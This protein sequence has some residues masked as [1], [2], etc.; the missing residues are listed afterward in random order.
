MIFELADYFLCVVNDFT[1]LDQRYLDRLTRSLQNSKKVFQE[2]IVVHNCKTVMEAEVM[3]HIFE[4]QIMHV[5]GKGK[6]QTTRIAAVNRLTNELEEHDVQWFKTDFSRHVLLANEDCELGDRT[7]PWAFALLKNWLRSAFVPVNRRFSVLQSVLQ[8]CNARL[9]SYF[10]VHPEL[11]VDTTDDRRV[12]LIRARA[13]Q[14]QMR[15][16]QTSIDASGLLLMRPNHFLPHVDIVKDKDYTIFLDVPGMTKE[17]IRLSRQNVTTIVKGMRVQPYPELQV[18][19]IERSERTYGDFTLTFAI[20]Q[21]YER[22]WTSM[23]LEKG[24]LRIVFKPDADEE[25]LVLHELI[26]STVKTC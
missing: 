16:Q 17:D 3:Q 14:H 22:K 6:L 15:L 21:E 23:I 13:R 4:S 24:V 11:I 20:P 5:Y 8:S 7:N 1:S 9:S 25:S 10:K 19:K 2:V 26:G 12:K 18:H